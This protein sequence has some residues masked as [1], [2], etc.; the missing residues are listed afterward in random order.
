MNREDGREIRIAK[1][2]TEVDVFN[3]GERQ[4]G[5]DTVAREVPV[6]FVY[7]GISH[8]VMMASPADLE[9]FALGFSVTEGIIGG[10]EDLFG[11][12][13]EA[14]EQGISLEMHIEGRRFA[15]LRKFRRTMVGR[16]GCGLCG[17]ESLAQAVKTVDPLAEP[18]VPTD[19]AVQRALDE[20]AGFQPLQ[21]VTGA[22]HGAVW[23]SPRG[24][25]ILGR[26]DVGRHNAVDK[27]IGA[28][29][30]RRKG[31]GTQAFPSEGFLLVSSRASYEIVQKCAAVRIG[32][33]VAVS[34]PTALAVDQ[35]R[36]ADMTLVAFAR[37]GRHVFYHLAGQ[38]G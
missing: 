29:L 12:D 9:D 15:E 13:V 30:R 8:A 22:T 20:L 26:E 36:A 34:A 5:S 1:A 21:A 32:C 7:N 18:V 37:P 6:A 2:S 24:E 35:A 3:G 31:G 23:C 11:L 17:T 19:N 4:G 27:L 33:L 16:T 28:M 10:E 14:G 25:V 38:S